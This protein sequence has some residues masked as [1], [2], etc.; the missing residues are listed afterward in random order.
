LKATAS[1]CDL[2]KYAEVF[3]NKGDKGD[4]VMEV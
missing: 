3:F 1:N 4:F 2:K